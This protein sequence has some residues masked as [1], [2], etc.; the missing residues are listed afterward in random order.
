MTDG[1]GGN[2]YYAAE[3]MLTTQFHDSEI[4]VTYFDTSKNQVSSTE[5]SSR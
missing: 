2:D 3:G 1:G 4:E 5:S